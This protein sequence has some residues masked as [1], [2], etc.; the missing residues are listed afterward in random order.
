MFLHP[1]HLGKL[2]CYLCGNMG[3]GVLAGNRAVWKGER[4]VEGLRGIHESSVENTD[5]SKKLGWAAG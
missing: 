3:M 5:Q 1:H 4:Q 2:P